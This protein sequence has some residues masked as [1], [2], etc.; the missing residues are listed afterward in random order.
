MRRN[1]RL[2]D[3]SAVILLYIICVG[4]LIILLLTVLG[5][6]TT[7]RDPGQEIH[8]ENMTDE[9]MEAPLATETSMVM[10]EKSTDEHIVEVDGPVIIEPEPIIEEPEYYEFTAGDKAYFDDALFIGDS[11]T[12]GIKKFGTLENADYFATTGLNL[13]KIFVTKMKTDDGQ[14]ITLEEKLQH[15]VYGKVYVM[16]GINELGYNFDT[17]VEKYR[18]FLEYIRSLQPD[19]ILYVCANLHVNDLRNQVDEIHNNAAI[20]RMNEVIA[21]FADQKNTFYLD[22]NPV[23]DNENG[24]LSDDYISD[25]SH[26]K[27]EY[28][29]QWCAWYCENVIIK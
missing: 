10:E 21:G 24:N 2:L 12:V 11:R 8:I 25:D 29:E 16:L 14:Q 18:E 5:G 13:Y 15:N 17:T 3:N 26:L 22:V 20:N 6:D 1:N 19:A 4:L 7:D 23:F 9:T 27:A 28:Y